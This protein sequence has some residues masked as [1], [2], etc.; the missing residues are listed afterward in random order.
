[1]T[2]AQRSQP[3]FPTRL[4]VP[5]PAILKGVS[6]LSGA[7]WHAANVTANLWGRLPERRVRIDE[8]LMGVQE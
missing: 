8:R 6:F 4:M 3:S 7:S 1:M 2:R 5:G